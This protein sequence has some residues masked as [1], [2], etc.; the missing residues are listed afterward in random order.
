MSVF[1]AC[2]SFLTSNKGRVDDVLKKAG[3]RIGTSEVESALLMSPMVAEAAVVGVP[4][5]IKG[6]A[7]VVFVI[8]KVSGKKKQH[9][10]FA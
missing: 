8:L 6:E 3:H 1:I 5:E 7:I 4:D 9:V 10:G 2:F